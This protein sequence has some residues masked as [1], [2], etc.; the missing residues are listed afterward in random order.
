MANFLK[1]CAAMLAISAALIALCLVCG[2]AINWMWP[3][4]RELP[5]DRRGDMDHV[6]R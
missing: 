6:Y 4:N 5:A 2:I 3:D 1:Y